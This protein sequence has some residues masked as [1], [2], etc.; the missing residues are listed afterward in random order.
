MASEIDDTIPADNEKV[1]KADLRAN[2]AAAKSE[3]EA[4]QAKSGVPGQIAYGLVDM[5]V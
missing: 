3:I 5:I 4:L 1:D 2:F